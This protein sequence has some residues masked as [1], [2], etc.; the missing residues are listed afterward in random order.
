M[1]GSGWRLYVSLTVVVLKMVLCPSAALAGHMQ[2]ALWNHDGYLNTAG[3]A[4]LRYAPSNYK[5]VKLAQSSMLNNLMNDLTNMASMG[6]NMSANGSDTN[7]ASMAKGT[8]SNDGARI[9]SASSGKND[10]TT[11]VVRRPVYRI[12]RTKIVDTQDLQNDVSDVPDVVSPQLLLKY[13]NKNNDTNGYK[14]G[15]LEPLDLQP[16]HPTP[17]PQSKASYTTGP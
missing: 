8:N 1:D 11:F 2:L 9:D 16:S 5:P 4:P 6:T 10:T 12:K 7:A 13:F 15:I 17:N 14:A 3:P